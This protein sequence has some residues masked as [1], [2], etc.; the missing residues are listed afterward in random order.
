MC[1]REATLDCGERGCPGV[2]LFCQRTR[3]AGLIPRI[4]HPDFVRG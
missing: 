3:E 4:P 1:V 2:E